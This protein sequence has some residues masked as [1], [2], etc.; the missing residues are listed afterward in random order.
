MFKISCG[1][2][3]NEFIIRR[4]FIKIKL[5]KR[6]NMYIDQFLGY[7]N[8]FYSY[9]KKEEGGGGGVEGVI[10]GVIKDIDCYEK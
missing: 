10:K 8:F 3:C 9:T 6:A 7:V 2:R 1:S 4:H 5:L